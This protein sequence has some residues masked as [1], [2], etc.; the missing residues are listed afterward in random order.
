[1]TE[2]APFFWARKIASHL[3]ENDQI[4][5]F[6]HAPS[7][8]WDQFSKLAATRLGI[9]H[10]EVRLSNQEWRDAHLLSEGLGSNPIVIPIKVGP[11]N[12]SAFWIMPKESV[13]KLTSWMMNGQIKARPLSSEIL[14]TGF[15]RYL[16]LQILDVVSSLQ[17]FEKTSILVSEPSE[18]P[19]MDAFCADVEISFD[20][21][22]CWG[23]LAIEPQ[24]QKSWAE[25]FSHPSTENILST[26]SKTIELTLGIKVGAVLLQQNEW[27]TLKA[28]DFIV[29]DTGS[30]D[31]RKHQGAA[32]IMLGLSPL[33]Q[34]KVKQNKLQLIDYAS[35]YE[36][37][38]AE[39]TPEI[40]EP[41]DHEAT[42]LPGAEEQPISLKDLPI[43][44][45]IELS[46]IRIT[47]EK[48][49][50]LSP[51][52]LIE[53]PIHPEQVVKLTVNGQLVG[54]AELVHLGE[55]LGIRVLN[56]S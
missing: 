37:P 49:M 30:Y 28:G 10:F 44:L 39:Y 56:L 4:P 1:V 23:R 55:T 51:G 15:Y 22:T 21:Q 50:E 32:T 7:F 43:H 6:G 33:F 40:P 3:Q 34:V 13:A 36:D 35:I 53:L 14:T 9:P 31:P 26:H 47:L 5:L 38:M 2:K 19:E 29:L 27:E 24:L 48:L 8:D 18:L 17:P 25:F 12:G 52:N 42:L 45:T 54:H 20:N 16:S 11:L 41:T 46:R